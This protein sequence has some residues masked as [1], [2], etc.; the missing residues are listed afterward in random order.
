MMNALLHDE[1]TV[2]C[3]IFN[4]EQTGTWK[5]GEFRR[6]IEVVTIVGEGGGCIPVF[7][8]GISEEQLRS[9]NDIPSSGRVIW[10]GFLELVETA[11]I[12]RQIIF[13]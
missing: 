12:Q 11:R 13:W 1:C 9:Q 2:E 10:D 4:N 6:T 5:G 3:N 7:V 8:K